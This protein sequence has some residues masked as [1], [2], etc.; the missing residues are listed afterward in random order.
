MFEEA[1]VA[2]G[3][4]VVKRGDQEGKRGPNQAGLCSQNKDFGFHSM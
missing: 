2:G 3:A 1:P 4:N